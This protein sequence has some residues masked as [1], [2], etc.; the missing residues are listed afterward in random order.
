MPKSSLYEDAVTHG[1]IFSNTH[2]VLEE[3]EDIIWQSVRE[4]PDVRAHG[5]LT[6]MST[7]LLE[8]D[9]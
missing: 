6:E 9:G 5:V 1:T 8:V 7:S 4:T 3:D 2:G